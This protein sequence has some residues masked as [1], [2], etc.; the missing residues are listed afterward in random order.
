MVHLYDVNKLVLV[1]CDCKLVI[2]SRLLEVVGAKL[3]I[4]R[5]SRMP[6]LVN[7]T[8]DPIYGAEKD[9]DAL[10]VD[11][12]VGPFLRANNLHQ[13]NAVHRE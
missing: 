7:T 4:L 8:M 5:Q 3:R 13:R 9:W 12:G 6:S 1:D 11:F 2:E 10:V